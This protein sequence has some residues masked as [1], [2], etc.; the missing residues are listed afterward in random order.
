MPDIKERYSYVSKVDDKWASL[1]IN[2]GKF[3]GVIYNYGKVSVS[4]E[5]NSFL[6]LQIFALEYGSQ[7][8]ERMQQMM[9]GVNLE[10]DAKNTEF[11]E[12]EFVNYVLARIKSLARVSK[13]DYKVGR[14]P[15]LSGRLGRHIGLFY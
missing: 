14:C 10:Q 7:I 2:G 11:Y 15:T 4:E 5:E 3:D 13:N 12:P 6:I 9:S 1:C 8:E